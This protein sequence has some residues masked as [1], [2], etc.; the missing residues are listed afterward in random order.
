MGK[1][2]ETGCRVCGR[3]RPHDHHV[4]PISKGGSENPANKI[5]LCPNHHD[6]AHDI[7]RIR[8]RKNKQPIKSHD[9]LIK[10]IQKYEA[11]TSANWWEKPN[12][13]HEEAAAYLCMHPRT[14]QKSRDPQKYPQYAR[15]NRSLNPSSPNGRWIYPLKNLK[16][17][18]ALTSHNGISPE[19]LEELTGPRSRKPQNG[20]SRKIGRSTLEIVSQDG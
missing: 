3:A 7:F 4:I 15:M 13:T 10:E 12:L 2:F 18:M 11:A 9:V 20:R 19:E 8:E 5:D 17:W 16:L 14:L 1:R 6:I